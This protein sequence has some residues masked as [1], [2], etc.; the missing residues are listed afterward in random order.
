MTYLQNPQMALLVIVSD[1]KVG[2]MVL[3][4]QCSPPTVDAAKH[5]AQLKITDR[6]QTPLTD[7]ISVCGDTV[8]LEIDGVLPAWSHYCFKLPVEAPGTKLGSSDHCFSCVRGT[9]AHFIIKTEEELV[10]NSDG[11][12]FEEEDTV[13]E[14]DESED[15]SDKHIKMEEGGELDG[16]LT[17]SSNTGH[18][19][20]TEVSLATYCETFRSIRDSTE[21]GRTRGCKGE[22]QEV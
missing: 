12:K 20:R 15:N 10:E 21:G 13:I 7:T 14:K 8:F 19:L 2:G 3:K 17:G 22:V 11:I 5:L 9:K 4:D 16:V 1:Q 6:V 18:S